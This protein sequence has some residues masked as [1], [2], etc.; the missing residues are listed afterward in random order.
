MSSTVEVVA[1]HKFP[2]EFPTTGPLAD[3]KFQAEIL[4]LLPESKDEEIEFYVKNT[5][6]KVVN[7]LRRTVTNECTAVAFQLLL[8]DIDT[9]E[10]FIPIEDLINRVGLI[11]VYQTTKVGTVFTLD[12]T[13][14]STETDQL[15]VTSGSLVES[16]KGKVTPS[17]DGTY[18]LAFL[19]PGKHLKFKVTVVEGRGYMDA[20]FSLTG[21]VP[22]YEHIDYCD[23]KFLGASGR[24]MGNVVRTQ[25]IIDLMRSKEV[26]VEGLESARLLKQK[27]LSIRDI[28]PLRILIV[29]NKQHLEISRP[30]IRPKFEDYDLI[31]I[32][33]KERAVDPRKDHEFIMPHSGMTV[34]PSEYHLRIRFCENIRAREAMVHACKDLSAR[35]REVF[36]GL[37][38]I[39]LKNLSK[40]AGRVTRKVTVTRDGKVVKICIMEEDHTL[41][42]MLAYGVLE[43]DPNVPNVRAEIEH[44]LTRVLFLHLIHADPIGIVKKV[45]QKHIEIFDRM[46]T[47]F[48]AP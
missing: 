48:L 36:E 16:T 39:D 15:F 34:E 1:V 47:V 10:E 5:N 29:P 3:A 4:S 21:S 26:K 18:R 40:E 7:G 46:A 31:L 9:D 17:C 14:P 28:Y 8:E 30:S 11:R 25:D 33:L 37:E 23:T 2:Y 20:K 35:L 22:V 43:L 12:V 19:R 27:S 41:G 42:H 45:C 38:A 6:P 32:N 24:M 44:P 13:N